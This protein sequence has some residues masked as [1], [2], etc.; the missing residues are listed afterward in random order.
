MGINEN[1]PVVF[2]DSS[3]GNFGINQDS[4]QIIVIPIDSYG[5]AF[6]D[7]TASHEN[8][9]EVIVNSANLDCSQQRDLSYQGI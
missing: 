8:Q 1:S 5:A 9:D 4:N 3:V 6:E 2:V 7:A